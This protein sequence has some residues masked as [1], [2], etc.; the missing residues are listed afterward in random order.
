MSSIKHKLGIGE[1][2]ILLQSYAY[3]LKHMDKSHRFTGEGQSLLAGMRAVLAIK[4]A[5]DE[6]DVEEM[7]NNVVF[8]QIK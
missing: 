4:L 1:G 2:Y 8:E 5:M 7:A 3:L 6:Q